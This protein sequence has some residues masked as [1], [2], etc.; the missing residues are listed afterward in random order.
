MEDCSEPDMFI[1]ALARWRESCVFYFKF[2]LALIAAVAAAVSFFKIEG[3]A[4]ILVAAQY[5]AALFYLIALVIYALVYEM[6]ITNTSNRKDL[7]LLLS[8]EK[9]RT[10]MYLGF[11][12]AYELQATAHVGLL[13]F[14]LG[15][16]S[17]YVDS[18]T[19]CGTAV[20]GCGT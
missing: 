1:G 4:V 14:A 8:G 13:I 7:T 19:E 5:K 9:K 15:F 20:S 3:D 6:T 11:K 12:W 2:D 18:F 17:G 10:W 16:A